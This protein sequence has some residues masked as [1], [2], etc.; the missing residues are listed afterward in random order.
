MTFESWLIANGKPGQHFYTEK[1]DKQITAMAARLNRK[2]KT[3]RVVCF[4]KNEL[5]LVKLTKVTL[6]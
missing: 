2:V 6:L 4:N 3:E 1:P 5:P